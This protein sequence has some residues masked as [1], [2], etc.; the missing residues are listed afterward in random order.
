MNRYE[1][2]KKIYAEYGVDTEAAL[3]KLAGIPISVHCWQGD[4]I[5]GFESKGAL[6][7]GI[8]VTGNY[9]GKASG[10]EQLM[11]DLDVALSCM[12]GKK[13]V[14]LHA[15]YAITDEKIDRDNMK[16]EYFDKWIE[17]AK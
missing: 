6:T 4:D 14:N 17:Y 9:P 8:Q 5:E 12:P 10:A 13:R 2:A 16:P 3:A 1:E 7:G 15:I 11:Q